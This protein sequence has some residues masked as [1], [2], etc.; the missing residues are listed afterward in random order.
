MKN[1]STRYN[2]SRNRNNPKLELTPVDQHSPSLER[3]KEERGRE[4]KKERG[5]WRQVE[6]RVGKA[7]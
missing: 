1:S 2:R 7:E 5:M 3:E 6:R 4:R